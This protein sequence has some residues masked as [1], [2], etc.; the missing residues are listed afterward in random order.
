[1]DPHDGRLVVV[2]TFN[3]AENVVGLADRVLEAVPGAEILFVDDSSPDG[4]GRTVEGIRRRHAAVDLLTRPRKLGLGSAY[5]AGFAVGCRRDLDVVVTMDADLSHDPAHLP[6]LLAALDGADVAIGSR[7]V[8]GGGVR[9][10]GLHRRLLSRGANLYART[11]LGV[12]VRDC[13]SGFRAY[14]TEVLRRLPLDRIESSGYSFLEEMTFLTHHH[15]FRMVEVPI[16]FVDRQGGRSK[17]S[18]TEIFLAVYHVLRLRLVS[19]VDR[20]D[21]H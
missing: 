8:P 14:R 10:W 9:N 20:A 3:E 16:V 19:V 1:M 6:D 11:L 2:P 4:T 21:R 15:G 12:P 18:T 13:T 5:R 17:I 7:Y